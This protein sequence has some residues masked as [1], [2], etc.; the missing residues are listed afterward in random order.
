ME[1]DRRLGALERRPG[2]QREAEI[3]GG[4]VERVN[5][6]VEI[7]AEAVTDIQASGDADQGLGEVGVNAPVAQLVGVGQG[8]A[9]YIAPDTHVI[10]L[11]VLGAQTGLD[12]A[13][14]LAVGELGEGHAQ[15]LIEAG[16][17]LDP[18]LAPIPTN[19]ASEGM[20]R[21]MVHE[22]RKDELASV[23]VTFPLGAG[24]RGKSAFTGNRGSSR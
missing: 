22:L 2:E 17:A 8:A 24:R 14:A 20:H 21:Q 15:V 7:D 23:H 19:T 5:G 11:G 1:F 3:D 4:G 13:Q 12:V 6:L 10:E 16:K 9:R 18:M